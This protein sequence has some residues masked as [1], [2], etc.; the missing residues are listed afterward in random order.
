MLTTGHPEQG[1]QRSRAPDLARNF[2]SG[3]KPCQT[4]TSTPSDLRG[5][6]D[7]PP[8][9]MTLNINDRHGLKACPEKVEVPCPKEARGSCFM[10]RKTWSGSLRIPVAWMNLSP[11]RLLEAA[12]RISPPLQR[13]FS[14]N[15]IAGAVGGLKPGRVSPPLWTR[16]PQPPGY[17]QI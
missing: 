7:Q 6:E 3:L 13:Q 10:R 2:G 17:H 14:A 15:I 1:S 5:C 8:L 12:L 4:S 16:P 9:I 11:V